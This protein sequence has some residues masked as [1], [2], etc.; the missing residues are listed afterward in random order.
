MFLALEVQIPQSLRKESM[1]HSLSAAFFGL[2]LLPLAM[3]WSAAHAAAPSG[4]IFT[5]TGNGSR[6]N[7]NHFDSKCAVYLDGGPGP[8]A[9][10]HAAGL[11]DGDY[12][13]Q[14][15]DPSGKTL[16]STDPVS[17]RRFKVANGVIVAY[18]GFGGPTHPIGLDQ[19]HPELG[20]I[21]IRLANL[22]CPSDFLNSPNNGGTYKVWATP[23]EDFV[24]NPANVDN[25]CGNGCFHG[26]VPSK[27]KTDNFKAANATA[28]FC[29]T[30]QKEVVSAAGVASP[31]LNWQMNVTD[32]LTVTNAYFTGDAGP[33]AG[34]VKV[35]GLAAGTYTVSEFMPD[36]YFVS[37]LIVNGT[38]LPEDSVYSFTWTVG[39]P[40]PIIFFR[41][42]QAG[43]PQ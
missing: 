40:E 26:F 39:K 20:A 9:P 28:T 25:A 27:S 2:A 16:L 43:A 30:L 22:N 14:V 38:A 3:P 11:P 13:F 37:A 29:L 41:N 8:N 31:G 17:N 15:T 33:D 32:P 21:T 1:K 34:Q 36:N 7:A 24:G 6:V 23:V 35:C 42:E 19:D 18:A 4:A 5:T 12:Y 10:A